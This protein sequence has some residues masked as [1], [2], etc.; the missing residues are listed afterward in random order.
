MINAYA[1]GVYT[2]REPP[3]RPAV[4]TFKGMAKW[5]GTSFSA[6]MVAGIIAAEMARTGSDAETAAQAVLAKARAQAI[7]GV[8]PAL[9]PA[10]AQ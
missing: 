7:S 9:Y 8:G 3:K 1:S 10:D 5:D 6:P 4:Q 2:Y